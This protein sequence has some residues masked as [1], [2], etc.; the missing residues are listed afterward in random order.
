MKENIL[1]GKY[2][3]F[4]YIPL[5]IIALLINKFFKKKKKIILVGGHCGEKYSDNSAVIHKYLLEK[6]PGVSVY[7]V[8]SNTFKSN[9]SIIGGE[10]VQLGSL[11]NYLLYLN[12]DVCYFSH[13]LST[14]IAPVIDSFLFQKSKPIR[15]HL[16]HG[17]EGL[18]KNIYFDGIEDVDFYVCSS[19]NEKRI[20]HKEWGLDPDKL[21]ITGVP[22]YDRLFHEKNTIPQKTI[23]YLPTWRE[24]LYEMEEEEFM[25][26][27]FVSN[28]Q[29]VITNNH[30]NKVLEQ[31]GFKLEILL[32]PFMQKKIP[33]LQEFKC[34]SNVTILKEDEDIA[35]KIITSSLL[36]TDY[37][38]VSWDFFYMRK[39]IIFY[40]FDQEKYLTERGAYIDFKKEL[41]G[42]VVFSINEL[43]SC[44]DKQ[45][46]NYGLGHK[47]DIYSY[48]RKKYFAFFDDKNCERIIQHTLKGD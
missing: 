29:E 20:K 14:D 4:K 47:K 11:K 13:S 21:I 38:S 33:F 15:V 40:Q 16:S 10:V 22:R 44:I 1:N 17:I 5:I 39:N 28:L 42:E 45:L 26:S 18:K 31:T 2:K 48:Q 36:I 35:N 34:S 23:L 8:A 9:L 25:K 32:H 43:V 6:Y 41:F 12:C 3:K 37:S 46:V 27:D 7:W 30:L 24:W 19:N